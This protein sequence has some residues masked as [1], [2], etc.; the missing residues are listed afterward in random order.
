VAF[1]VG[2]INHLGPLGSFDS[3]TVVAALRAA[4]Q[5]ATAMRR[6]ASMLRPGGRLFVTRTE[7]KHGWQDP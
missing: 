4:V 5:P 2:D 1:R 6:M 3:I 7:E